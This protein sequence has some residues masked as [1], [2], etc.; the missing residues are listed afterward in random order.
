MFIFLPRQSL[1]PKM[2]TLACLLFLVM[3]TW[4]SFYAVL[5]P[6]LVRLDLNHPPQLSSGL[7]LAQP[8]YMKAPA[9]KLRCVAAWRHNKGLINVDVVKAYAASHSMFHIFSVSFR[10]DGIVLVL[11]VCAVL[12][13]VLTVTL[14]AFLTPFILKQSACITWQQVATMNACSNEQTTASRRKQDS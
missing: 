13:C 12:Y 1:I 3:P 6:A 2:G 14:L 5:S 7:R 11:L 4:G 8:S 9:V 10:Y